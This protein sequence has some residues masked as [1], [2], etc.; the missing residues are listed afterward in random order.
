[1]EVLDEYGILFVSD[2]VQTGW[3]RTGEH[4][5]GI[6]AHGFTPDV[7]TFA[8][9]L[10]NGM[11]IGGVVARASLMDGIAANSI[12]TFGGNPLATAAA[13]ATV[14][15][16]VAHDLQANA[17]KVGTR[18]LDELRDLGARL[19]NVGDVRGKGL[20]AAVELVVPGTDTPDPAA[21]GRAMEETK[22][23]GLLVGK[24]GRYGNVLRI[25]PPL[26]LT[27]AEADEGL[28]LLAASLT[29]VTG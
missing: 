15:Y 19:P 7:M 13:L 1:K 27:E 10:G 6:G 5:W 14:D 22:A 12:S 25:A 20:M 29:A 18:L 17:L 28:G 24:G 21:A 3:G 2:E 9:G 8:K 26:T 23:R 16:V 11:A 4:F